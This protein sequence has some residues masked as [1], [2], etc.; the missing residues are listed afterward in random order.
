[1]H[2]KISF[3]DFFVVILKVMLKSAP[4]VHQSVISEFEFVINIILLFILNLIHNYLKRK[5]VGYMFN[6]KFIG[7][8]VEPLP[9]RKQCNIVRWHWQAL[10]EN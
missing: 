7:L 8:Y 5:F 10:E 2:D 9:F 4:F 1:M 6:I 3:M